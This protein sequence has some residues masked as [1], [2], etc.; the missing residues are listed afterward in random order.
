MTEWEREGAFDALERRGWAEAEV[1]RS[2]ATGFAR[3]ADMVAPVLAAGAGAGPGR[4]VIDLCSGHGNVAAAALAAG[5][6]VT[7]LDFSPAFL[8]LARARCPE[9]EFVEGNAM[10][11]PFDD[12]SA[13]GVT[14]GF[15][16]PHVPDPA[17]LLAE[18]RRVLRPDGRLAFSVWVGPADRGALQL[19]FDA[20]A[21]EGDPSVRLPPGPG[22]FDFASA[23]V[24][25]PALEAA[26]FDG[27]AAETVASAFPV[28]DPAEL[29]GILRDGTV[30]M[31]VLMKLQPPGRR[32][33]VE[34]WI[35]DEARRRFG[36]GPC[37]VPVPSV[38]WTA[39]AA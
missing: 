18:A 4:H 37:E 14:V 27:A 17:R 13:D 25:R 8:A 12:G 36:P 1:A 15:G 19:F 26:G 6:R 7:G 22:A 20:L 10:D 23:E 29:V 31:G 3:A 39:G 9:A 24:A 34:A 5:A 32:R 21:A 11:L 16:M 30:R 35:A 38:V 28:D 2:Y 33:A